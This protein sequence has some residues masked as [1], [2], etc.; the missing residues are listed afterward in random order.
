M[1]VSEFEHQGSPV[2]EYD[3]FLKKNVSLYKHKYSH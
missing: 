1:N 3:I 2:L